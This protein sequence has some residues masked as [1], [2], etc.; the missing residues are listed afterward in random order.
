MTP[1]EFLKLSLP[2]KVVV[3]GSPAAGKTY[4]TSQIKSHPIIHADDYMLYGFKDALYKMMRSLEEKDR[5]VVEGV[6]GYRLLRKLRETKS[7]EP[8]MV[9]EIT[10]PMSE[11]EKV[12]KTRK[13]DFQGVLNMIKANE[14]VLKGYTHNNWIK[15]DNSTRYL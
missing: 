9:V 6:L 7:W 5:F 2:P 14:T 1:S 12:Y 10:R 4:L 15:V 13:G 8:D 11:I 3:I